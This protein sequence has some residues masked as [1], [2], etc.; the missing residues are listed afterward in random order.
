MKIFLTSLL[1][2]LLGIAA[3][4]LVAAENS[5]IPNSA[6]EASSPLVRSQVKPLK[7]PA[8]AL[9]VQGLVGTLGSSSEGIRINGRRPLGSSIHSGDQIETDPRGVATIRLGQSSNINPGLLK[10]AGNT[11]ATVTIGSNDTV[12]VR[13]VKGC[14]ILRAN[15]GVVFTETGLVG[16]T[17]SSPRGTLD[18]CMIGG[19]LFV[20]KGMAAAALGVTVDLPSPSPLPTTM[21]SPPP[22]TPTPTPKPTATPTP[23][24]TPIG[25]P[26]P[27]PTPLA[28]PTPRPSVRPTPGPIPTPL[29]YPSPEPSILPSPS[30]AAS[31]L[32]ELDKV[33]KDLP[34]GNIAFNV[35]ETIRLDELKP[36]QLV[37]SPTKSIEEVKKEVVET[38]RVES[39]RIQ[40]SNS[41]EAILTGSDEAFS[42]TQVPPQRRPISGTEDTVWR[43]DV[44]AI[45][46][47]RQRLHVVLNAFV[48]VDGVES[49][50]PVREFDRE[51]EIFV[52]WKQKPFFAFVRN[53]WQWL[54]TAIL[55]PVGAW[56]WNQRRKGKKVKGKKRRPKG[57]PRQ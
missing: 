7:M 44:R 42:I 17:G 47:G 5:K 38:G 21:P 9:V 1:F 34:W 51:Y 30:P 57:S 24:P 11:K 31:P 37:L 3:F 4:R 36:I 16:R 33:V 26:S 48:K 40:I 55:L 39:S 22:G 41:M 19:D 45:K 43:W 27:R 32:T 20:N 29:V 18:V 49:P 6:N 35:P 2:I 15:Q 56:I 23:R 13:L 54:W 52:P 25:T 14:L 46:P 12:I 53:N 10:L 8:E 50:H 28:T